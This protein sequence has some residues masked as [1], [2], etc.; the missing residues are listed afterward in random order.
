MSDGDPKALRRALGSFLSGVTVVTTRTEAGEPIGFTANSFTSV[1]LDPPL[2]LVC[3]GSHLSS[4]EL[5]GRV[6]HF[7]ISVL[8]EGQESVSNVFARAGVDRFAQAR[9]R[10]DR[11]G[12]PLIDGACAWFSCRAHQR[13][14]AGDH[15]ILVGEI[16]DFEHAD[17]QGLGYGGNGYFS[18]SRERQSDVGSPPGQRGQAGVI[19]EHDARVL[20]RRDADGLRLP[21]IELPD[22]VGPRSALERHLEALELAI[23]LGPVYSVYDDR[24]RGTRTTFFRARARTAN[25]AGLGRFEPIDTLRPAEAADPAVASMLTRFVAEHASGDF[26]FYLGTHEAGEVHRASDDGD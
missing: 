26:G 10:P 9:W 6:E 2:L 24:G 13:H 8:A 21:V 7:A 16:I 18:L 3:P 1:S 11:H 17:R 22:E 25:T 4:F 19:V 14:E 23:S 5:F 15:L 20:I 12:S